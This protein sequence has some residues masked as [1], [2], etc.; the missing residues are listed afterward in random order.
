M[1]WFII[2]ASPSTQFSRVR[3]VFLRQL[4]ALSPLPAEQA[5][6]REGRGPSQVAPKVAGPGEAVLPGTR[7]A[8]ADANSAVRRSSE[9]PVTAL[10][11]P[12]A[13]LII[14][15]IKNADSRRTRDARRESQAIGR[16]SSH[17]RRDRRCGGPVVR[18]G[19]R[20]PA[21]RRR[22]ARLPRSR[23]ARAAH[24]RLRSRGPCQAGA[25]ASGS[26]DPGGGGAR[27][28]R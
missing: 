14:R 13:R 15:L 19:G 1:E 23:R 5:R 26:G 6:R 21:R 24:H 16:L 22:T 10:A 4:R 12:A 9:M 7:P 25:S 28:P 3:C 27:A 8:D 18:G 17:G 11:S 2:G 20:L